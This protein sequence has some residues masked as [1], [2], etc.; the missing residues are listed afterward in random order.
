MFVRNCGSE[1]WLDGS[2]SM[3]FSLLANVAFMDTSRKTRSNR[4]ASESVLNQPSHSDRPFRHLLW[5]EVTEYWSVLISTRT[6]G[7]G[8]GGFRQQW[9]Q[10][11]QQDVD[12]RESIVPQHASCEHTNQY[13]SQPISQSIS[14][15]GQTAPVQVWMHLPSPCFLFSDYYFPCWTWTL[16]TSDVW[17]NTCGITLNYRREQE[18][19]S[20]LDLSSFSSSALDWSWS[21]I[22][23]LWF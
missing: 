7:G 4:A 21:I 5:M 16:T 20:V 1:L 11:Q 10:Q 18:V 23:H 14:S 15:T 9:Q 12:Q 22:I 19:K 2:V 13:L 3:L 8:G 6:W 17:K